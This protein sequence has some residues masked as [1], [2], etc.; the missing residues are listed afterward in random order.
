MTW[1]SKQRP[2]KGKPLALLLALAL[3]LAALVA[4]NVFAC[5]LYLGVA[6][7][8]PCSKHSNSSSTCPWT[9]CEA[10]S[11][12]IV[13]SAGIPAPA[14]TEVAE[15]HASADH[16]VLPWAPAAGVDAGSPPG[17]P[18]ELFLRTHSLLI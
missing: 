9:I 12:Y 2:P 4:T 16:G 18:A 8:A 10:A 7:P 17:L 15:P 6:S 3:G 5:P 14:L 1:R 13:S 11:S